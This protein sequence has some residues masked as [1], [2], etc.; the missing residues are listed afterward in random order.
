MS[1]AKPA[2]GTEGRPR[3][4]GFFDQYGIAFVM[5]A[6]IVGS[7]SI[8]IASSAGV[9][10]GYALIWAFVGSALLG[11]MAQD[12]SARLGIFGEPLMVFVQRKLGTPVSLFIAVLI[13]IGAVLWTIELTAA[14]AKG[15]AVLLG[16]AISWQVL[17]IPVV[18]LAIIVGVLNYDRLEQLLTAMLVILLVVY[19]VVAGGS[20]PDFGA[21]ASGFIPS[22]PGPGALTLAASIIGSTAVWSNF[23]L[24]SNLVEQKGWTSTDDLSTMRT[25]LVLGYGLAIVLIIAVLIVSAAILRP[26]GV[27]EIRSYV[28][29]GLALAQPVGQWAAVLFLL[30]TS[31]A[32]FNSIMPV[33]WVP[34]YLLEHA[35]GREA[36]SNSRSFKLIYVVGTA[37]GLLAPIV[38]S[39]SGLNVVEMI[40]LFPAYNGIIGLPITAILLY[41]AVN[42]EGTMG[43]HTN[44]FVLNVINFVLVALALIL[45]ATS[46]P[47]I[48]D[49]VLP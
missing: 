13:S 42:D 47:G 19:L 16:G 27:E 23:F 4:S 32:A 25:D 36:D 14:A 40:T 43:E 7:G 46:L 48:I 18:A 21:L 6:S 34:S 30:G 26:T 24:E 10:Y 2:T 45:A 38:S 3:L 17:T 44:G 11:I 37:F 1:E 29:P 39:V 33:M 20:T 41:W 35:L 31:A 5:V 8:F 28:A 9:Q 15:V 49:L 22:L 12:M